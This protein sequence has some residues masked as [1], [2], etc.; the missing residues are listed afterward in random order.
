MNLKKLI[1]FLVLSLFCLPTSFVFAGNP[2]D[3]EIDE[4]K[5]LLFDLRKIDPEENNTWYDKNKIYKNVN[6]GAGTKVDL[7]SQWEYTFKGT[8]T[9][10]VTPST[11]TATDTTTS[12]ETV[13]KNQYALEENLATLSIE[14]DGK[15]I[16]NSGSELSLR[17]QYNLV[18]SSYNVSLQYKKDPVDNS[19]IYRE[20]EFLNKEEV[21]EYPGDDQNFYNRV[22]TSSVGNGLFTGDIVFENGDSDTKLIFTGVT[23]KTSDYF[24]LPKASTTTTTIGVEKLETDTVDNQNNRVH[25][26]N[27]FKINS[28]RSVIDVAFDGRRD[29]GEWS[30]LCGNVTLGS[31][32]DGG[33]KLNGDGTIVK[34]GVGAL[35]LEYDLFGYVDGTGLTGK[36]TGYAWR[37]EEGLLRA[38]NQI[39]LGNAGIYI[40]AGGTLSL[41]ACSKTQVLNPASAIE[42]IKNGNINTNDFGNNI[43]SAGGGISIASD[44]NIKLT[45]ALSSAE[46]GNLL[47]FSFYE[48]SALVLTSTND[49]SVFSINFGGKYGG[50]SNYLVTDVKGLAT[51]L[52][53]VR[54][55][56]GDEFKKYAFFELVLN[57]DSDTTYSGSLQGEMYLHKLGTGTVNLSGN[58]TFS[59]GTYITEG[60]LMLATSDALGT[61]NILFDN[62]DETNYASIGV[63]EGGNIY[64]ENNIHV[65]KGANLDVADGQN[66]YLKGD[67][68]RYD[69]RPGYEAEF[70]KNGLGNAIIA[71]AEGVDRKINISTF[72]V[73]EGGFILDKGVASDSYFSISGQQAFLE[74]REN[75]AVKDNGIDIFNGDLIIFN[76]KCISSA[77]AVVFHSTETAVDSFSKFH[78]MSDA[79]LSNETVAVSS[80]T[81]TQNI[82]FVVGSTTTAQAE[83]DDTAADPAVV[84]AQMDIFDFQSGAD[85]VIVKSGDGKFVADGNGDFALDSLYVNGGE[86]RIENT[87]MTAS[88]EMLIDNGGIFS[89]SQTSHFAY[90]QSVADKKITVLDGGIGI[91][92]GLS[93]DTMT[94]FVYEGTDTVN[95]SKLVIESSGV[96]LENNIS[97]KAGLEIQNND[98]FTF[99]GNTITFDDRYAG[100]LAKSGAGTMTIDTADFRI[101]ELRALEGNL[102]VNSNINVSTISINGEGALLSFD[103]LNKQITADIAETLLLKN[104]GTLSIST[105]T[106]KV[107]DLDLTSSHVIIN[108]NSKLNTTNANFNCSDINLMDAS[109][110]I[111]ATGEIN[112]L[113]GSSVF[114]YGKLDSKVNVGDGSNIHVGSDGTAGE[115]LN[116]TDVVFKTGSELYVDIDS[117]NGGTTSDRLVLSGDIT[118]QKDVTLVVNF[119]EEESGNGAVMEAAS[120]DDAPKRFK[121]LTFTGNYD[122]ANP[123]SEIF[124]ISLLGLN[125]ARLSASTSLIGKSIFL[126]IAQEFALYNIPGA[127]KNQQAMIDV[128]NDIHDDTAAKE[129]LKSIFSKLDQ[130]YSTDKAQFLDAIQDLSGIFYANSFMTSAMLSNKANILYSRLNENSDDRENDNRV[131]AHVYTNSFS[132]AENDK[133]PEFNNSIYGII[134]GYDTV[135]DESLVFGVAG[136]YGQGELKQLDDKADVIDAGVNVYGDYKINEKIDVK[137]LIGYSMQDY[138]TTRAIRYNKQEI[139]SKYATNTISL[140]LEAAYKLNLGEKLSL[141]PLAGANCAVVSNGDIEEDGD[142]EQRLK[143]NKGTYTRAEVR[144]GA[145]LQSISDSPF[146]WHVSA[147]IKHIISGNK[148]TTKSSFVNAP[149]YEFELES[150]E[151]AG[152]SFSGLF[153][154]SYDINENI[155][156]SLDINAD[157]GAVSQFGG[158]IG[159]SY[160]W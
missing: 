35:V 84:T 61:G 121:I 112:L 134:A 46:N 153:G 137:G 66:L 40:D 29:E 159:A 156:I 146:N 143:I 129:N 43:T 154:C 116:A 41:T 135:Q 105:A 157:A 128:F 17:N 76:D 77:T 37:I 58:N 147:A 125:D 117:R 54:N 89:V 124:N 25:M 50:A 152:T 27:N 109:S 44:S 23:T 39:G 151:V 12:T 108:K 90:A 75:A 98:S 141:K 42:D 144:V 95:L 26:Y 96:V 73:T 67:L 3:L 38:S 126:E 59:E 155:N 60:G 104:N 83:S 78:I 136:F 63:L 33:S 65:K 55:T 142:T 9:T 107:K 74:V 34:Q 145:G 8:T 111:S 7:Y 133:N 62:D 91:Y 4:G 101:K 110:V 22:A 52:I 86:F 47:S 80:I 130:L 6:I 70:V 19:F 119:I 20:G 160:K 81:I 51:D 122:F 123:T 68:V 149:G 93:I 71:E 92:N 49:A 148:F 85:T 94:A 87:T 16:L 1:V 13:T 102:L 88:G 100:I 57:E 24:V 53:T 103:G 127:T 18:T 114:G 150:T 11:E 79:V 113:N 28:N 69:A 15:L 115:V 21:V 139:T 118:V 31:G 48:N 132:V 45:G 56:T 99:K 5:T 72:T 14:N 10:T 2:D 36:N 158:N 138:D 97:V 140:D 131:W 64:L 30:D 120:G 82:E 106:V 32:K